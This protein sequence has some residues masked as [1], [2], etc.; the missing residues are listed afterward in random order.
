MSPKDLRKLPFLRLPSQALDLSPISK[1]TIEVNVVRALKHDINS[2]GASP[3]MGAYITQIVQCQSGPQP[4]R[5]GMRLMQVQ[6]QAT[7]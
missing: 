3:N 1:I 6:H 4:R 5:P 2:T 7:N